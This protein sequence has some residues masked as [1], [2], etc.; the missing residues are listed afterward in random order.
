MKYN[1]VDQADGP[2]H[3]TVGFTTPQGAIQS[4][5]AAGI[6]FGTMGTAPGAFYDID[7]VRRNTPNPSFVN[8]LEPR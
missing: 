8:T 6:G 7:A 4:F 2:G 5:E 3:G 1:Q